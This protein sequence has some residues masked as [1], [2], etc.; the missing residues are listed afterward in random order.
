MN[1]FLDE[2]CLIRVGGRLQTSTLSYAQRHPILLPSR[3]HMTDCIIR[4]VH[5]AHYHTGIQNTLH[6][7][8]QKFW[9]LDG[10]NQVRKIIRKCPRTRF[11]NH[12]MN[13][14]MGNLPHVRVR[15]AIPF[16]N[17]GIDFCRPFYIKEKKYRN[18]NRIKIYVCIF[19]CMSIKAVHFEVVSDLSDGGITTV[20][21]ETG[22]I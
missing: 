10:R 14:K 16:T 13:Y 1:P 12:T 15:E 8:R 2:T 11:S 3:H 20:Y 5:E 22:N 18:R 17:T 7:L 4:E 19:V 9:L 21:F 6:H